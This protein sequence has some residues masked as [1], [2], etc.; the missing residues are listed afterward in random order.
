MQYTQRKVFFLNPIAMRT[1][2]I[3]VSIQY[4]NERRMVELLIKD[5]YFTRRTIYRTRTMIKY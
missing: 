2:F 3:P 4:L 1:R 5:K